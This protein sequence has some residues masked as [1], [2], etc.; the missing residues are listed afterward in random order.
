MAFA[1]GLTGSGSAS[2]QSWLA[3][4]LNEN[5]SPYWDNTSSDGDQRHVG[6]YLIN[7][8]TAPLAGAPG[9]LPFWGTSGGGADLSFYFQR[10]VSSS[11]VG[12]KLEIA[13][14]SNVN[15]FGW[16]DITDPSTLYPLFLGPDA[17]PSSNT[18][19]PNAQYGFYLK[20]LGEG[21]YYTQS[22]LNSDPSDRTHQHFV[23]FQESATLGAE[24][25]WIGIE[26]LSRS[27]LDGKE[28]CVGDYNDMIVRLSALSPSGSVP[29]PS[30]VV[31]VLAGAGFILGFLRRRG[32][33]EMVATNR[34]ID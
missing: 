26:D 17:A 31:L 3:A 27:A 12:L 13:G 14:Q 2:L 8:L 19:S 15:E 7:A 30:T 16:Y 10:T 25:Y 9:T 5:G 22:S 28:D 6:Y 33:K 4:D 24:I 34:I 23:V 21:T 11:I 32:N 1:D 20:S 18:F 29:E